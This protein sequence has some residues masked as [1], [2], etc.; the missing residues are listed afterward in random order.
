MDDPFRRKTERGNS[1]ATQKGQ[2]QT[3]DLLHGFVRRYSL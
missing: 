2:D 1:E 3:F